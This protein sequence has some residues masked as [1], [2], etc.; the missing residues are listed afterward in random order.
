MNMELRIFFTKIKYIV[1][2]PLLHIVENS[3]AGITFTSPSKQIVPFP[4]TVRAAP[5]LAVKS[6][7][8]PVSY[9]WTIG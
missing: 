6:I 5:I 9:S 3:L 1:K 7:S 8:A 2:K 4:T